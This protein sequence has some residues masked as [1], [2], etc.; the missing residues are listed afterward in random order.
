MLCFWRSSKSVLKEDLLPDTLYIIEGDL[1]G[2][3]AMVRYISPLQGPPPPP[4]GVARLWL[5]NH[6]STENHAAVTGFE[7]VATDFHPVATDFET[8][9]VEARARR[10]FVCTYYVMIVKLDWLVLQLCARDV[11][12]CQYNIP[13][14]VAKVCSASGGLVKVSSRRI[15]Y[16]IPCIS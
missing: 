4:Q 1:V 8:A 13:P 5:A 11:C 10:C 12:Y 6:A 3:G 16:L 9:A 2:P 7:T 14:E 15:Y